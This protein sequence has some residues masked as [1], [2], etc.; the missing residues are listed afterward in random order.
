MANNPETEKSRKQSPASSSGRSRRPARGHYKNSLAVLRM[1]VDNENLDKALREVSQYVVELMKIS[2]FAVINLDRRN[3]LLQLLRV[4]GEE[5][6]FHYLRGLDYKTGSSEKADAWME[7]LSGADI[8]EYSAGDLQDFLITLTDEEVLSEDVLGTMVHKLVKQ[9]WSRIFFVNGGSSGELT[10]FCAFVYSRPV[11]RTHRKLMKKLTGNIGIGVNSR[12]ARKKTGDRL[13]RYETIV[14]SQAR[15][16]FLLKNGKMEFFSRHLPAMLGMTAEQIK[17]MPFTEFF[18]RKSAKEIREVVDSFSRNGHSAGKKY[19][20]I[21]NLAGYDRGVEVQLDT[22]NFRGEPAVRGTLSDISK[23]T[24]LEKR[25]LKEKYM[26]DIATMAG[27][28]AHDFNNLIG[29]M[30]GYSSVVRKSLPEYDRRVK[31]LDKI[32]EA[33][34]RARKLTNQLLSISRKGKYKMGIVDLRSVINRVVKRCVLPMEHISYNVKENAD[35]Y[36]VEGD[37]SQLYEAFLNICMNAREAMPG[38]GEIEVDLDTC[39]LDIGSRVFSDGMKPGQYVRV[40][41]R[42]QGTGINE[43][44][45]NRVEVPF[46]TTKE[47]TMHKG[48]GLP[49]AKGIVENHRGKMAIS[50]SENKGTVVTVYLPATV[51]EAEPVVHFGEQGSRDKLNVL[52]VDDEEIVCELAAEMLDTLGH[53]AFLAPSGKEALNRLEKEDFDLVVLDLVM[54]EMNGQEVF[55]R[56]RESHPQLPVIISS[57]YSEDQVVRRLLRDGAVS[58]LKKPYRL[59]DFSS[60]IDRVFRTYGGKGS[61]GRGN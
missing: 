45:L 22:V 56:I 55:R 39:T 18:D 31:Q 43:D 15:S 30:I 37:S 52:V 9:K 20:R 11:P 10:T 35:V 3:N 59:D 19:F 57:G 8:L 46:F 26:E 24:Q 29:A 48:L 14:E 21:L 60:V 4:Q 42:D 23:S 1:L 34:I 40:E 32:E 2:M 5:G 28:V 25:L 58:F 38:G 61:R 33:G 54:P 50:S 44:I 12:I 41:V 7:E 13:A 53:K 16:F 36:N 49:A 17:G 51:K 47:G 27:G 6:Q